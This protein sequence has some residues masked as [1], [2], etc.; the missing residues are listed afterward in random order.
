MAQQQS[1]ESSQW[2]TESLIAAGAPRLPDGWTYQLYAQA[3]DTVT[4][5]RDRQHHAGHARTPGRR[6]CDLTDEQAVD[7][8]R[9]AWKNLQDRITNGPVRLEDPHA[10]L[11]STARIAQSQTRGERATGVGC[12]VTVIVA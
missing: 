4:E 7:A 8:C 1:S 5:I 11:T 3:N 10:G 9:L 2:S 6:P 12:L